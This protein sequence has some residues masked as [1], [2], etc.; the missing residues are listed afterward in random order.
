ME[1]NLDESYLKFKK[2]K[3]QRI[4]IPGEETVFGL[5]ELK[6]ELKSKI[7]KFYLLAME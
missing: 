7:A 6:K 1:V 5:R 4:L 2:A 3:D